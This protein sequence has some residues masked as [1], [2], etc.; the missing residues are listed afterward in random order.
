MQYHE[1][2]VVYFQASGAC[3]SVKGMWGS[4]THFVEVVSNHLS[5]LHFFDLSVKAV[6]VIISCW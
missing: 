5:C 1:M 6:L 4:H 3:R 2:G